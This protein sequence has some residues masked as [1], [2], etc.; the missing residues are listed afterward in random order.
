[1]A[2][3]APSFDPASQLSGL[4]VLAVQKDRPYAKPG[5]AVSM[6]LLWHDSNP[7]RAR[8]AP[9]IAWFA[10]CEN[11]AS[12]LFSL[13]FE[14]IGGIVADALDEVNPS[15]PAD[16]VSRISL[17]NS[18]STALADANDT[19]TFTVSDDI[20][21]AR[22]PPTGP[23]ATAY[24]LTYVFFAVCAGTLGLDPSLDFPVICF[25]EKDG[26]PGFGPTDERLSSEAFVVG[27]SSVYSYSEFRNA[28]PIIRGLNFRGV[29][30]ATFPTAGGDSSE[31]PPNSLMVSPEDF[32]IG[33]DCPPASNLAECPPE[34][35]LDACEG[36]C[37][38]A[39]VLPS[40]DSASAEVDDAASALGS[41]QLE[42]QMWM[43]YYAT[44]G[45]FES[46]DVKLLNDAT[47]GWSENYAAQFS[48][49]SRPGVHHLWAVAH[50]NR[51]GSQWA[52]IR[53]CIR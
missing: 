43:N 40:V 45:S 11:P 52:R 17:P 27:Y 32:C 14:Q 26:E 53:M 22:P 23:S 31:R 1:M 47:T 50:D 24:G 35:T 9:Q 6:K 41:A 28:N 18:Q 49:P 20:I 7:K 4:R 15:F 13:C 19:F 46:G 37:P 29:P 8:Q 42:E 2:N 16:L 21:S 30:L 39:E 3:C 48:P 25:A 36:D 51:G 10:L 5:Q 33:A 38:Q 34:L 44:A 12:D